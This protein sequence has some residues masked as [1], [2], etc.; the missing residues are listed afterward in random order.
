[1]KGKVEYLFFLLLVQIF[2]LSTYSSALRAEM[3]QGFPEGCAFA[4]VNEAL[5]YHVLG[6]GRI[7]LMEAGWSFQYMDQSVPGPFS[8]AAVADNLGLMGQDP[9]Q[10]I[11]LDLIARTPEDKYVV[12]QILDRSE[13]GL[14][15]IVTCIS[16]A[17]SGTIYSNRPIV[18]GQD[19][20][21]EYRKYRDYQ[22]DNARKRRWDKLRNRWNDKVFDWRRHGKAKRNERD[23]DRDH[24]RPKLLQLRDNFKPAEIKK[25]NR[26]GRTDKIHI[27]FLEEDDIHA[28]RKMPYR[29]RKGR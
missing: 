27:P 4:T 21:L 23:R 26:Q 14:G 18:F 11:I 16:P 5:P 20:W 9:E 1:M 10:N 8:I 15:P 28:Q 25:S 22:W 12:A 24:G 17:F 19:Y 6:Y 13:M 7:R 2:N 3:I 29:N